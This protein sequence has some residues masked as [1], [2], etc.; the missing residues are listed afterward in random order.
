MIE[1]LPTEDHVFCMS[2]R[3]HSL[4]CGSGRLFLVGVGAG[5]LLQP[6]LPEGL[7]GVACAQAVGTELQEGC[8]RLLAEEFL[9]PFHP[10]VDQL[11]GQLDVASGQG[12]ALLAVFRIFHPVLLVRLIGDAAL[13]RI[14]YLYG[15]LCRFFRRF[16]WT[17]PR[18]VGAGLRLRSLFELRRDW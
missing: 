13:H 18:L 5:L 3:V 8:F 6:A 4:E 17:Y 10:D 14:V 15:C 12:Q 9:A 7:Q 1:F 2:H 16:G 11:D